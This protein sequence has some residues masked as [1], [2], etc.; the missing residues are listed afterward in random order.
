[1]MRAMKSLCILGCLVLL[2]F[3]AACEAEQPAAPAEEARPEYRNQA[4][5]FLL[6][7]SAKKEQKARDAH[8]ANADVRQAARALL[9][10]E[11]PADFPRAF[12][13]FPDASLTSGLENDDIVMISQKVGMPFEDAWKRARDQAK[14]S[15]W[16]LEIETESDKQYQASFLKGSERVQLTVIARKRLG[17][18]VVVTLRD[19]DRD[20]AAPATE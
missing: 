17:T 20:K 14:Q 6:S 15:G 8:Q 1:M 19:L 5:E 13:D 18:H 9:L 11:I 16:Q 12:V 10:R 2:V 3:S 4:A 7:E